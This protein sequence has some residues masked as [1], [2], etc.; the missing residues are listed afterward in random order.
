MDQNEWIVEELERVFQNSRDYKQ[1]ALIAA[2]QQLIK[3]QAL[4]II[5]MEGE[6]DGTLWSPRN[7]NE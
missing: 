6:L 5:Q 4:R 3:E 1:K 2:A 7:W